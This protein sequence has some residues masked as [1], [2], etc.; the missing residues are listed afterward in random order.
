MR[1][2]KAA[3]LGAG[4]MG[5][6]IAAHLANAGV[7]VVLL[8]VTQAA[9]DAGVAKLKKMSPAPF[10]VPENAALISTGGFDDLTPLATA[11]WIIEAIVEKLDIKQQLLARVDEIRAP[12]AIV[13]SNTSG[14]PLAAIAEG[15]SE[16]FRRHW[17]GTHFF[18]P[19]RYLRLVELIST[20]E[21]DPA[22]AEALGAFIDRRLGKVVVPAPDTPAFIANHLGI[23]GVIQLM[24]AAASGTYSIEE[25]DAITGPPIGRPKSATFRTVDI[26]G[27]D[28]LSH[29]AADLERRLPPDQAKAFAL[30]AFV[31]TMLEKGLIGDK[32]GQG[33]YKKV[34]TAEGTEI[35]TLDLNTFEYRKAAK[36]RIN[37]LDAA[38][39]MD[40]IEDRLRF[41][42]A[43]TDKAGDLLRE[44]LTPT[45]AYCKSFT[46][47]SP[48][49]IDLALQNGFG[50]EIGPFATMNVLAGQSVPKTTLLS[51]SRVVKKND[52]ASL[53]DIGDGVLCVEFHSKMNTIGGDTI[54]MLHAGVQEAS[55]NFSALVVGNDAVNFCAGANLMLVLLS[56]Q[57]GEWD[58][59][60]MMVRGFQGAM[61]ALKLSPVPV[62]VAPAG[63]TLGGG[64]EMAL[65]AD[66]VQAAAETYMGLVEVGVGLLPAGGGTKELLLRMG[67]PQTAF[68]T[69]G[70][71]KV[72]TSGVEARK[73]GY[74]RDVDGVTMNRDHL[75]ADAKAVALERVRAGYQA[76]Q[77]RT[78]IKVGGPDVYAML[79]LGVH[80]AWRAGRISDHD[81]LIGRKIARVL[82]GGDV[83]S[84]T[85]VTEQALLDIE[86]EGFLSL[87]GEQKTLERIAH[88]LKTGKTLRN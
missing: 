35:L 24:H 46:H 80:L 25:I 30:P 64:C 41:L 11:D 78:D 42:M 22:I 68:E 51:K 7:P 82:S 45:L 50:W 48:E 16:G 31:K 9:A 61:M 70:F 86:R 71:A 39:T 8:D 6:Q 26:A 56:A 13:S 34:K 88:T 5:S 76:P 52:G 18:N 85:T 37:S 47:A 36:A 66:R 57:E 17:I 63:L 29:V 23:Y 38:K 43:S 60:D 75:I 20:P 58:D 28:V 83:T 1:I 14:I 53:I 40:S 74:L 55:T 19:P 32:A 3:V 67:N 15:R 84:A 73:I 49:A 21:T 81:A 62:V 72:A 33:F 69:I 10:F 59:I 12:E 65:H 2:Q 44:T 87:C 4:V 27:L 54:E 77:L 79:S